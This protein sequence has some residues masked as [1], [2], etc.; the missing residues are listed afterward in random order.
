M[1]KIAKSAGIVL[2][3]CAILLFVLAAVGE[4]GAQGTQVTTGVIINGE[5]K[6]INSGYMG[7][8]AKAKEDM[9]WLKG[10]AV[11]TGLMGVG[12]VIASGSMKEEEKP[13]Y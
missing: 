10:I 9:G 6:E 1:K 5:Y 12:S 4:D 8:N 11:V 3:V 13:Q 2:I 7:Y